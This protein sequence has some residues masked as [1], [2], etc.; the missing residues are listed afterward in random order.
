MSKFPSNPFLKRRGGEERF[1]A[2]RIDL[3]HGSLSTKCPQTV[4]PQNGQT[5]DL[6]YSIPESSCSQAFE[7]TVRKTLHG[8][9]QGRDELREG[10]L[11]RLC[12]AGQTDV[13]RAEVL[14]GSGFSPEF[15]V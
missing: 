14:H 7:N 5:S 13:L 4:P 9:L 1:G 6:G 15:L 11:P 10:M 8:E 2:K 3:I 12:C